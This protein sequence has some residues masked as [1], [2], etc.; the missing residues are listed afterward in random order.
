MKSRIQNYLL[1]RTLPTYWN[2]LNK[3][4]LNFIKES[5]YGIR[6][7]VTDS[8]TGAKQKAKVYIA[9]H[10]TD[11]S[12][13]YS[14]SVSGD[15]HRFIAT[16][17][18]TLT[19]SSPGYYSKTISNVYAKID[20]TTILNIQL[21]PIITPSNLSLTA[22]LSGYYNGTTMVSKNATV[23]LHNATAPYTLVESKTSSFKHI[24][25]RQSCIHIC[26]KWDSVLYCFK[27]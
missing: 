4:L 23:E 3:S 22:L 11:S 8:I 10:D 5:L 27:I 13:V 2:N 25:S 15:Y 19:F 7:I 21:V 24:R 6:G 12:W 9:G 1:P 20:S 14:D 17:T 18:Y 16:G 26:S